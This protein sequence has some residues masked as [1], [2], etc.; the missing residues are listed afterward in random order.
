[1]EPRLGSAGRAIGVRRLRVLQLI[2]REGARQTELASRALITKQALSEIVDTLEADGL[3]SRK[4]DPL[5]GRAWLVSLS[6]QGELVTTSFDRAMETVE[7][8]LA[9]SVGA[10]D[11][12]TFK[13][14]LR[15]LGRL[16]I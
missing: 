14:V 4:P 15:Q 9:R 12:E 5:D 3:V 16:E 7:A 2:P 10:Q 13:R 1:M 8:D 11:Y 6:R